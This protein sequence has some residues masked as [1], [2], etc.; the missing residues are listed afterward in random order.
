MSSPVPPIIAPTVQQPASVIRPMFQA[1][2]I[3]SSGLS[4]QQFRMDVVAQNLAN[5][6]TTRTA[7]GG[8]YQRQTVSMA[9]VP[10]DPNDDTSGGVQITGVG[11]DTS[12]GPLVYQP[13]HPD[14]DANGYVRMPNVNT[15]DEML[16]LM[17]AHRVFEANATVFAVAKAM[18][19]TAIDI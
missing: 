10:V 8:P 15:T 1:L 6:E 3:A 19:H 11:T 17:N 14:A 16:D 4:A 12:D 5:A 13:G 9:A 2:R 7:G 18:L